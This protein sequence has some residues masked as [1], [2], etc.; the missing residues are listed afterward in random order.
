MKS[1]N[2]QKFESPVFQQDET[3]L[4][5]NNYNNASPFHQQ[6]PHQ[7]PDFHQGR[8]DLTPRSQ[9]FQRQKANNYFQQPYPAQQ[10]FPNQFI[11]G[12]RQE[13]NNES[14]EAGYPEHDKSKHGS[15]VSVD[16]HK[17]QKE[18][19]DNLMA[20]NK[21]QEDNDDI[22]LCYDRDDINGISGDN[23]NY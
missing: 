17:A 22:F 2:K 10:Q 13:H 3:N 5:L 7:P 1:Q 14:F 21:M 15:K 4:Q 19:F 23:F 16:I 20:E 6:Y 11:N 18:R 8:K 12:R 9:V